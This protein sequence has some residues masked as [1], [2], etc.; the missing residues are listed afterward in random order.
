[1][2]VNKKIQWAECLHRAETVAND[3]IVGNDRLVIKLYG[4]PRGGIFAA[5]LV[6][7]ALTRYACSSSLVNSPEESDYIIDDIQDSGKTQQRHLVYKKPFYALFIKT[8]T[9]AWLSF[10]WERTKGYKETVEDNVIRIL[11]YLGE[12]VDRE[13]LRNTPSRVVKSWEEIYGGYKQKASDHMTIFKDMQCEEMVVLKDIEFYSTCEHHMQPFFGKAHIGYLPN[14]SVIGVSKL[15][16]ILEVFSRRLQIQERIGSQVT[17]ALMEHLQPHGC[18][19]VLEAKHFCM[20]CRGVNKQ[21]SI[22]ITSS[23]KGSFLSD[24][25]VKAE[26]LG[27]IK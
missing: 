17:D 20:T 15:A 7:T 3:I 19:C 18:A 10:P 13:G 8:R 14:K 11:Q 21:S 22:M 6:Q 9:E 1:M 4:V 27:M 2:N 26:F 23:M 12:E 16:R 5:L 25:S 24:P